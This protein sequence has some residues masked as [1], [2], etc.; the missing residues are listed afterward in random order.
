MIHMVTVFWTTDFFVYHVLTIFALCSESVTE[1]KRK[2]DTKNATIVVSINEPLSLLSSFFS[3]D[4]EHIHTWMI[5]QLLKKS[6]NNALFKLGLNCTR[7]LEPNGYFCFRTSTRSTSSL[8]SFSKCSRL[9][10]DCSA[11]ISSGKSVSSIGF[12]TPNLRSS[13]GHLK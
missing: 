8:Q 6:I 10:L 13:P 1:E 9:G 11:S 3:I 4:D 12:S 7:F 5:Q 2:T